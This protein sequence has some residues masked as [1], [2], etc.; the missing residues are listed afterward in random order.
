MTESTTIAYSES[1]MASIDL[2][3]IIAKLCHPKKGL[4]W[5]LEKAKKAVE[6]YRRWLWLNAVYG[7]DRLSPSQDVDS[8]WHMHILDTRKYAEDCAVMFNGLF[9]HHN[10]YAGWESTEAEEAHQKRYQRTKQL[11]AEHFD[12][13]LEGDT[14]LC[15]SGYCDGIYGGIN[16]CSDRQMPIWRPTEV[17]YA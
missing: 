9:L 14:G 15:D 2:N 12:D 16:G 3:P 17:V 7:A 5:K 13:S 10:P 1:S 4:G 8:V 11:Y 6:Q